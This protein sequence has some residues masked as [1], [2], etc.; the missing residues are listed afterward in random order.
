MQN[1]KRQTLMDK[2]HEYAEIVREDLEIKREIPVMIDAEGRLKGTMIAGLA[3]DGSHI[4]V[5]DGI[6]DLDV[7]FAITHE[8][9][10]A[11]QMENGNLF[12]EY[13]TSFD[14]PD[15]NGYNMQAEE[16]DANAYASLMMERLFGMSPLFS[17]VS[18]SVKEMIEQRKCVIISER[19]EN[20][21]KGNRK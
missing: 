13:K 17:G 16:I 19:G 8:L 6:G 21:E 2:M 3:R 18:E 11:W 12:D 4:L 1:R 10:H 14:L 9:R 15:T 20:T 5:R 7:Y